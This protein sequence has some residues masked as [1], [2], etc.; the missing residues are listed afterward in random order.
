MLRHYAAY[1]LYRYNVKGQVNDILF[2]FLKS[3]L[4]LDVNI[5]MLNVEKSNMKE[6]KCYYWTDELCLENQLHVHRIFKLLLLSM[7]VKE[8]IRFISLLGKPMRNSIC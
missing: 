6:R 4:F 8:T 5:V 2:I 7:H 1:P 3:V